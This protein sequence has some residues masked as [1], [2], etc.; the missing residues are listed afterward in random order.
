MDLPLTA[1]EQ[2]PK[3]RME[4]AHHL[5]RRSSGYNKQQ[6][7]GALQFFGTC[8]GQY[9]GE[10]SAVNSG[11]QCDMLWDKLKPAVHNKYQNYCQQE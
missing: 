5:S 10:G 9:C 11:D 7:K 2:S 4:I 3:P 6:G 1:I 8:R